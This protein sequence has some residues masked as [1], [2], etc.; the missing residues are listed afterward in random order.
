MRIVWSFLILCAF[1]APS[2]AR[3]PELP[4]SASWNENSGVFRWWAGEVSLPSGFTYQTD[5]SDTLEGH[6]TSAD[7]KFIVRHDIGLYAGI[8]ANRR[9]AFAFEERITDGARV[10]TARRKRG[11]DGATT[12]VAVT[13]PDNGC[14]NFYLESS[15]SEDAA[16]IDALARTFRPKATKPDSFCTR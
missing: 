8:W 1:L 9:D 14:A 10:W 12:L 3:R 16:V 4:Q 2:C 11:K 6:F 7:G 15:N 13:F 5:P